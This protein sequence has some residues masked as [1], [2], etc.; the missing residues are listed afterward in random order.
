MAPKDITKESARTLYQAILVKSLDI[1][2]AEE[3]GEL[4]VLL[5]MDKTTVE[6][7]LKF[8]KSKISTFDSLVIEERK[9]LKEGM[10]SV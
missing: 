6:D 1:L 9:K 3:E 2:S 7:V 8:L 5:D 4:D 10:I